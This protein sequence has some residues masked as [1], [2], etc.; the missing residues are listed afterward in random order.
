MLDNARFLVLEFL[1]MPIEN[2][3]FQNEK[4]LT[5]KYPDL[6][7]SKPVERAVQKELREGE[8]GPQT[9]EGRIQA[10]LDRIEKILASGTHV[11]DEK[12][13]ELLKNKIMSEFTIDANDPDT[14]VKIAHGLYESEKKLATEQGRGA[15]IERLAREI[16]REGGVL[17]RYKGLV[18]EKREIQE[19]TLSSWLDY[20]KQDDAQYPIWFRYYVVR[21]LQKMG[22]MD[23]E[24][25]EYT[26]R[27]DYTVAPFPELNSEALGFVYRMLTEG[28]GTDEFTGEEDR[29]KRKQLE[30]LI[31]KK[32][33][34]KLY[35]FAQIETAGELNRETIEGQWVK[36][37]QGSDHHI[38]ENALRGKGTGWCTAEGSA[39]GHLQGGDFYVYYTKGPDGSFTEPRIAIRTENGQ[40]AE[41][42]GVNHRQELEPSFV[43][44]A[45]EQYHALPGGD[46]FDKKSQDMEKMTEL[47]G[48]QEKGETFTKDELIFLY[49]INSKIEGFG[50]DKDPRIQNLI[51]QRNKEEDA[52]LF[53]AKLIDIENKI[54]NGVTLNKEDLKHLYLIDINDIKNDTPELGKK[55]YT[56]LD[57]HVLHHNLRN[58]ISRQRNKE[59]DAR[60]L[61]E[62]TTAI[63]DKIKN[64][65]ALSKQDL[66]Y[67]YEIKEKIKTGYLGDPRINEIRKTRDYERDMPI[68]FECTKKQIARNLSEIRKGTKAYV[69]E[70]E[71]DIFNLIEEYDIEHVYTSFPER[72]IIRMEMTIGGM[73]DKKVI[74]EIKQQGEEIGIGSWADY[75][76]DKTFNFSKDKEQIFLIWLTIQDLGLPERV[77]T[78]KVYQK[79][80]QFGLELCP[81]ET[82]P[83]LF[84][85]FPDNLLGR[86]L[87]IPIPK[88]ND[89]RDIGFELAIISRLRGLDMTYWD[90]RGHYS[91][92]KGED[93]GGDE[94]YAPI[95]GWSLDAQLAF[96]CRIGNISKNRDTE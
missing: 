32:D 82:G 1:V 9:K 13:W 95:F 59:E 63:E 11:S 41:V 90:G 62:E 92:G 50:Y 66:M 70:L 71:P 16:E 61:F 79:A 43:D 20:L 51:S 56:A 48:K 75:C 54:K 7:G 6:A 46:K 5:E 38:L 94:F 24:R 88:T 65:I 42:R 45:T 77:S 4:F 12:G 28:M 52:R 3:E 83:L 84:R 36:Y 2:P 26:K 81:R 86:Y 27:T 91:E 30:N 60:F 17:E 22:T 55:G 35:T 68:V 47:V 64:K 49:E 25:G 34:A 78:Y 87:T 58:K 21:N 89:I 96:R 31:S 15:D 69:G 72:K 53:S 80:E 76:L 18:K 37:D 74:K 85:S 19:S 40:V 14:M 67:L 29:E 57:F 44:I 39:Y 33:F 23:K 93:W 8:K 73:N 10:Y